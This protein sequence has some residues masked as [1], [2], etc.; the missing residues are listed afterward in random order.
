[1]IGR[2]LV[3]PELP[4]LVCHKE[5]WVAISA[6][7]NEA[8]AAGNCVDRRDRVQPSIQPYGHAWMIKRSSVAALMRPFGSSA[9]PILFSLAR[10]PG[11]QYFKSFGLASVDQ[12]SG[13]RL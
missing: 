11:C 10:F 4:V 2:T 13:V 9:Q 6:H 3:Q 12:A 7:V 5:L 1:M 8:D